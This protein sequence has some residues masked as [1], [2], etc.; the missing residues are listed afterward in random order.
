MHQL[1]PYQERAI[2]EVAR[3]LASGKRKVVFQLA[4]GGGK[5]VVFTGIA[6]RYIEKSKKSVLIVVH[7]DELLN[8]TRRTMHDWHG[9]VCEIVG[10]KMNRSSVY[11]S[12]VETLNNKL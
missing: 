10:K 5:T 3:K 9:I 4:T 7:R 6:K 8:Q 2:N 12:M 1:R 11:I